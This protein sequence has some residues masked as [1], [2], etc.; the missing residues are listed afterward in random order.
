MIVPPPDIKKIVDKLAARVASFHP[1]TAQAS[2]FETL[3]L[4]KEPKNEKFNFLRS[5]K[6]VYRPYYT[7]QIEALINE[8]KA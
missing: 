5:E 2:Q 1:D 7:Q 4:Q 6:D 3:I 8:K